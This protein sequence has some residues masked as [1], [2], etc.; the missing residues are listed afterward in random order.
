MRLLAQLRPSFCP[1]STQ[2]LASFYPASTLLLPTFYPDSPQLFPAP[3]QVLQ[4]FYPASTQLSFA[5]TAAAYLLGISSK[6]DLLSFYAPLGARAYLLGIVSEIHV[7][8]WV[9]SFW[10]FQ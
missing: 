10:G 1:A 9:A 6:F 5:H 4:S 8:K 2:L 3:A 7:H